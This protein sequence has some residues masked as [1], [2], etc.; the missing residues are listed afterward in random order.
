MHAAR[1][2]S[3]D[4]VLA[5]FKKAGF[6]SL[7]P[8]QDKVIPLLLRGKDVAGVSVPGSGRTV[9][10]MLPLILGLRGAGLDPRALILASDAEEVAKMTRAWTRVSRIM[11][12]APVFVP[13]GEIEDARREQRRLEKGATIVAGTVDRVIDHIRRGGLVFNE[14][15]TLVI[16]EPAGDARADFVKDVQFIFAKITERPQVALFT[17]SPLNE[18]DDLFRLLHHPS[19]VDAAAPSPAAAP[20]KGGGHF[21]AVA[22]GMVRS[23]LLARIVLGCRVGSAIVHYGPRV[24]PRRI[25]EALQPRGLRA[26]QLQPGAGGGPGARST[27][28]RRRALIAF[29]QGE[30]DVLL[31]PLG[32]GALSPAER[33]ELSP[34]HV[35]FFDLPAGGA[36]AAVGSGRA[37]TIV[38]LADPGQEKELTRLQ[39]AVG[40]AITRKDV[41]SDD[42]V[43][44]GAIDRVLKRMQG[45]DQGELGRLRSRI[46]RQVPLLQRPLFMASLLKSLLPGGAA[47]AAVSPARP[48]DTGRAARA[49]AP[50]PAPEAARPAR[51]RFGRNTASGPAPARAARPAEKPAAG[52]GE[53]QP[54]ARPTS[55][56]GGEFT[57]LFVS[58]GRNRRVFQRDLV[59]LFSETL[60]LAPG[61]IGDVRV[62]EKYSFVDIVPARAGEAIEK[63]SGTQMKGRTI[64]VNYAKKKEEKEEA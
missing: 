45:E 33:E 16:E 1:I 39:E 59:T 53:S 58:I 57:Q 8:F 11:R 19:I 3:Q 25:A 51:G 18:A 2:P 6:T 52:R 36:R 31:A 17:R 14:L 47:P 15:Q 43:L 5:V 64:A 24:D 62:F 22:D 4:E 10:F 56:A 42:E 54:S 13:L 28:E 46:R 60:S 20:A 27:G 55:S 30:C 40:V 48:A 21:Y 38:A 49:A 26:L 35:V 29:A 50:S 63:L 37:A 32:A 41:P 7:T 34:T 23:D 44:T 9:G 12:D 61:E